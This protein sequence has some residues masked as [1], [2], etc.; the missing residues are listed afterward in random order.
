M[1]PAF[2]GRRLGIRVS[3]T[4]VRITCESAEIA[5]H[6]RSF[7]PADVVLAPA[8]GRAI[9][10]AREARDRLRDGEPELPAVDLARYDALFEV[11]A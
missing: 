11:P 1:P 5:V 3:P 4:T 2:V 6:A 9:R 7:V 8:H 10:L